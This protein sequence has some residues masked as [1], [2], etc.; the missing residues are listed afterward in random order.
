MRT[1]K[2]EK[3]QDNDYYL[4]GKVLQPKT[5][6]WYRREKIA[7]KQHKLTYLKSNVPQPEKERYCTEKTN[8]GII[9]LRFIGDNALTEVIK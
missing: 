9:R 5:T 1:E 6:E 7:K 4:R 2:I 3:K 8:T